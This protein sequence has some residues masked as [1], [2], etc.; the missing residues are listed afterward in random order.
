MLATILY[1]ESK[2]NILIALVGN[3]NKI[4]RPPIFGEGLSGVN[5]IYIYV[6]A[7]FG[8]LVLQP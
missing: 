5:S 6:G 1:N 3:A 2:H 8:P 7:C 4:E